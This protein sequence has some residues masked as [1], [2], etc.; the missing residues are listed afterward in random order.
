MKPIRTLKISISGVRGVIGD[1][2]SPTLLTRFAESFGTYLNS[3]KIV[4]GRDTRTSGEM[5]KHAVF[6]GLLATGCPVVDLDI[7]PVPTIQLM[8]RKLGARGGIAITA[9]HNPVE[10]NAL[11]L[12]RSDGCFLNSYQAEELLSIYHQGDYRKARNHE[13]K[14][15]K[16]N[17]QG[18]P[19][20]LEQILKHYGPVLWKGRRLKVAIDCCNGAG[21]LMTP[22]LLQALGCDVVSI[23][24]T[25]D[26]IFPHPPEPVPQNLTDLC[27]LVKESGAD[28][29]FAQDA[30]ADRLAIVSEKGTPIGEDNTLALAV[31]FLLRQEQGTVVT[32][33]STTQAIDDIAQVF[34]CRVIRT[35]IGEVNV[36]ETMKK[37]KALIGG[38]G[39][40]GVIFPR[41]NFAR[42]SMVGITLV[43]HYMALTASPLSTLV[44]ELP[45]YY[46]VKHTLPCPSFRVRSF[47]N[48]LKEIYFREKLDLT[49]GLK[50]L[51]PDSWA[52]IRSSNTEPIMRIVVEARNEETAQAWAREII[53]M[54]HDE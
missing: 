43:L 48:S 5:V 2:L 28:V 27:Q 17:S 19:S 30:D 32:N 14:A 23:N 6:A 40:G 51:R 13:I 34:N 15:V 22:E 1:S 46:F 9:S 31:K 16:K 44:E 37:E 7:C 10:W 21:S 54:M 39:N 45:R 26:G 53:A 42:D 47:L 35:R 25:P 8:V 11:K 20:H 33:L 38:E 52:H 3:G 12:I 24:T 29:G 49:D 41:I 18:I 36:T 4:V 50:I